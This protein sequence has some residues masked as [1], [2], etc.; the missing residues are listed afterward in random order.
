MMPNISDFI[1]GLLDNTDEHIEVTD[2]HQVMAK[3]K[4]QVRIKMCDD[5]RDTFIAKLHNV[6]L[7]TDIRDRLFS[8]IKLMSLGHT[9]LFHKGFCMVYFGENEKNAVTLPNSAQR[10]H[11]F[12]GKIKEMSKTKILPSRKKTALELLH[13]RLGHICTR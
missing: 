11:V 10:K 12:L 13:Q 8:I 6:I 1:P 7:A 9:C 5:I 4:G 3:Q 2:G